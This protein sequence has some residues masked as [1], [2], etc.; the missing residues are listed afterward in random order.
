MINN[1]Q[2]KIFNII[3]IL[4]I[5]LL[6]LI[7]CKDKYDELNLEVYQYR[8]TKELVKFVYDSAM[9]FKNGGKNR[10]T[11]FISNRDYYQQ[12]NHYLYIYKLDGTN[13]FHAGMPELEGKNLLDVTDIKGKKAVRL[14]LEALENK[15]NPHAWLHYIWWTPGKFYPA[16]KSSCQF[17]VTTEDGTEYFVGGGLDYPHEEKEFVRIIVDSAVEDLKENGLAAIDRISDPLSQYEFREVKVFAFLENGDL[18]ISPVTVSNLTNIDLLECV[19]EVNHKPF[20]KAMRSLQSNDS[21]WE[22]FMAKSRYQRV[23]VKKCLYIKKIFID[24]K[25]IFVGAVTDL[26]QP[27]WAG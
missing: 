5:S 20:E 18:L 22:V 10:L 19:D 6:I 14:L 25:W 15:N 16:P 27:P 26:P 9:K 11:P 21:T 2:T 4:V 8:D 17:K 13:V 3:L 12:E 7:S 1:N 23:L 24:G